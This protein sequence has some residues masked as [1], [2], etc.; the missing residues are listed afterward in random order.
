MEDRQMIRC[1]GPNGA[2]RLVGVLL[3][4]MTAHE[5]DFKVSRSVTGPFYE[6]EFDAEAMKCV[7]KAITPQ[8][9]AT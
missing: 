6:I 9:P 1:A 2:A 3:S 8:P 7:N 4:C 5:H